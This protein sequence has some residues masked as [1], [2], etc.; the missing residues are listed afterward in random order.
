MSSET[1]DLNVV[2]FPNKEER[3]N[4]KPRKRKPLIFDDERFDE[5]HPLNRP[6]FWD[7]D[8]GLCVDLY[9]VVG[10]EAISLS[11]EEAAA[12]DADPDAW[13]ADYFNLTLQQYREWIRTEGTPLCG[14]ITKAGKPCSVPIGRYQQ[15]SQ[16]W[17]ALHRSERCSAH[18]NQH[19]QSKQRSKRRE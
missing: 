7:E 6:P 9:T 3:R 15:E 2:Q 13:A 1:K 18:R 4:A 5:L 16:P 10:G 12:Y 14:A 11:V 17:L 8:W 19:K